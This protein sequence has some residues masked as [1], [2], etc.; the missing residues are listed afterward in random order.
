MSKII[1]E[2]VFLACDAQRAFE[3]F[4]VNE[5]VESWLALIADVEAKAGGKYE[6]FWRPDD[7][8]NDSTIGCTIT[9]VEPCAFISFNWKGPKQFSHFMN[10][11]DPLTHVTVLFTE[12]AD[13]SNPRIRVDLIHSG[14]RDAADWEEARLWFEKSWRAALL[15]L[16]SSIR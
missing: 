3:M 2:S 4:T 14:W 10:V 11:A 12:V 15:G 5:L 13:G 1:H 16:A 9:A 8:Q 7:R 6:L